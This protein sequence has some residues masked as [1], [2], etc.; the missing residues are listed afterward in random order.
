MQNLIMLFAVAIFSFAGV[1]LAFRFGKAFLYA[2]LSAYIGFSLYLF[3]FVVDVAGFPLS[4]PE[5]SYATWFLTTDILAEHYGKRDAQRLVLIAVFLLVALYAISQFIVF[6][7]PHASDLAYPHLA[8]LLKPLT[9]IIWAGIVV[10]LIEQLFDIWMF[11]KIRSKTKGKK[12]WLR[13]CGSTLTTQAVDVLVF[14]PL[15]FYGVFPELW[16]LMLAGYC[17]KAVIAL[18]DTPFMYLSYKIKPKLATVVV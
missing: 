12:L 11:E 9:R 14:Y 17:F 6:L 1:L 15:A 2:Y 5:I 8:A 3:Y 7:S 13:N 18:L 16:K 10:F 4:F